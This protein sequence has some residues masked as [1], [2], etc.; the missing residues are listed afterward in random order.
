[1]AGLR[2]WAGID[3]AP[4]A[5]NCAISAFPAVAVADG[6]VAR[7]EAGVVILD[8]DG[9][10]NERTGWNILYL[11]IAGA[12]EARLGQRL[13]QG[14]PLG[15]PSCEGGATTGTHLHIARKYNGEWIPI[16]GVIPFNLE[17]WIVH[18]G[19]AF[20]QGTLRRGEQTVISNV[21]GNTG[22]RITAGE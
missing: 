1:L 3:F 11:H 18:T 2:P 17:G 7:S 22:S 10:G 13:K 21:N 19:A 6:V 12:G 5:P 14:D 8:L 15:F 20:Y 16:D 9:D 4:H